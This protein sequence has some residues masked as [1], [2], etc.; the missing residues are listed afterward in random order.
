[1]DHHITSWFLRLDGLLPDEYGDDVM[2]RF[3]Q[4][5]RC[6]WHHDW[7]VLEEGYVDDWCVCKRCGLE[8][9]VD[10]DRDMYVPEDS[11][12]QRPQHD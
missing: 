2:N 5:L 8:A 11:R 9:L 7:L 10:P 1:M 3:I 12:I 4:K 6:K